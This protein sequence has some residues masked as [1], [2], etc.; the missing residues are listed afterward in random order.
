MRR[1]LLV[2]RA[3]LLP[4]TLLTVLAGCNGRGGGSVYGGESHYRAPPAATRTESYAG[5]SVDVPR[6]WDVGVS[7]GRHAACAPGPRPGGRAP[8]VGRPVPGCPGPGTTAPPRARAVWLDS[9]LPVGVRRAHGLSV[10]TVAVGGQHVTAATS[11]PARGRRIV[12]SAQRVR[13]DDN[14][15]ALHARPSGGWP[16]QGLG[17]VYSFDVCVYPRAGGELLWSA[18]LAPGAGER[19]VRRL[20]H[21]HRIPGVAYH[22]ARDLPLVVLV[23][24]ADPRFGTYPTTVLFRVQFRPARVLGGPHLATIALSPRLLA[25]WDVPGVRLYVPETASLR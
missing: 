15:C 21:A 14:G 9:P 5:V 4:L 20:P 19:F 11:D 17:R 16:D 2:M 8:Y 25:P 6:H 7:P 13:T 12:E 24:K 23:A 22:D 3:G 10:R 18:T 1:V